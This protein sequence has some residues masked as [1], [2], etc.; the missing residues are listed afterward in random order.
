MNNLHN[1]EKLP[2]ELKNIIFEYDGRIKYKYK[3][4]N[5]I[6]YHKYVNIIHKHDQRYNA[7]QPII[8]TENT[9]YERY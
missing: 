7:I 6:D 9:D 4:K 2:Y 5:S 1:M 8:D 3:I